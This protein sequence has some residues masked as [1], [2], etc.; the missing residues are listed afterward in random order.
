MLLPVLLKTLVGKELNNQWQ[1]KALASSLLLIY[2]NCQDDRN[3]I[4]RTI[5]HLDLSRLWPLQ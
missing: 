3:T 4:M 1:E 5:Q 2:M